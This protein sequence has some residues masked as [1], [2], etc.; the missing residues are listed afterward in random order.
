[1]VRPRGPAQKERAG[2]SGSGDKFSHDG[3]SQ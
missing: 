2:H 1:M 3:S